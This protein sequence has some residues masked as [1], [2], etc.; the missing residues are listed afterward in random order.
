[1]KQTG[2]KGEQA[3]AIEAVASTGG[4][5]TPPVMGV[6]IFLMAS[7]LGVTYAE[8]MAT[9]LVPA[10]IYY[11]TAMAGVYLIASKSNIPMLKANINRSRLIQGAPLFIIPI[12]LITFLLIKRFTP[13]YSA[14]M[15]I[16][17]L[18][19]I[20]ALRKETRPTL[21]AL[22]NGL[23]K[24]AVMGA[25]IAVACAMIGMFTSMLTFT[26]AGPK[27]AGVIEILA[28]GNLFLALFL[29]M[30]LAIMLGCAMPTPVAYV[31]TALVVAPVLVN[32]GLTLITAHFFVF[33]FAI[34]SS[35]TPPVAGAALVGSRIAGAEYMKT[36]WES[37]KLVGPFFLVPYFVIHNPVVLSMSQPVGE[38]ILA[39][40]ALLIAWAAFMFFC[41]GYFLTRTHW[42]ERTCFLITTVFAVFYGQYGQPIFLVIA[43]IIFVVILISLWRRRGNSGVGGETL[44]A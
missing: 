3:G 20:A 35:V 27:I 23:A 29:T 7:F 5:L 12:G 17:A 31:V 1:M 18:L 24:G 19:V 30:I 25:T 26:G 4:Q 2:F 40:I 11:L 43:A 22:L 33:Y 41:Q 16:F 39:L 21:K 38:A 6:A 9:A 10:V 13:A 36:G 34:L 14:F 28:G 44:V 32:M 15:A 8:L 42:L 37:L